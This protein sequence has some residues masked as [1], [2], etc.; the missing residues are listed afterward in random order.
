MSPSWVGPSKYMKYQMSQD[1]G[2]TFSEQERR[3]LFGTYFF[4]GEE[5]ISLSRKVF[6][7]FDL[8]ANV[9]GILSFLKIFVQLLAKQVTTDILVGTIAETLY[10]TTR[11]KEKFNRV[12]MTY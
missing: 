11:G 9:G 12:A 4:V 7:F 8:L 10:Y 3:V 6:T 1:Q 5:R 2:K